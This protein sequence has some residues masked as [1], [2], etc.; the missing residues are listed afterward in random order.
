MLIRY[1]PCWI[2]F[3]RGEGG[4]GVEEVVGEGGGR[5]SLIIVSILGTQATHTCQE[6]VDL[7]LFIHS[8][9]TPLNRLETSC[10]ISL[11]H[12]QSSRY[13]WANKQTNKQTEKRKNRQTSPPP[14]PPPPPPPKKEQQ[15]GTMEQTKIDSSNNNYSTTATITIRQQQQ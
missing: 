2:F 7:P 6:C 9:L 14:P 5:L 13:T 10:F 1:D 11:K 8:P 15:T 4:R 3:G 12:N